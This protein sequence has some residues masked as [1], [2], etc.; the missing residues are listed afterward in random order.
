MKDQLRR[1]AVQVQEPE[2]GVF[3]WVLIESIAD[4]TRFSDIATSDGTYDNWLL[5][6]VGGVEALQRMTQDT[7]RGPRATQGR[8]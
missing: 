7:S 8:I 3:C 1:I 4:S 6:M 5:A 2:P